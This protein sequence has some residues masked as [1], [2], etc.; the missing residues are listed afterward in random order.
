MRAAIYAELT[1]CPHSSLLRSGVKRGGTTRAIA[2]LKATRRLQTH[3]QD[4]PPL[5]RELGA[6]SGS[7][8][9]FF[10]DLNENL[11]ALEYPLHATGP[12]I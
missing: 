9:S 12:F 10:E 5:L 1:L 3:R 7:R 8:P 4:R 2:A 11:A 6:A